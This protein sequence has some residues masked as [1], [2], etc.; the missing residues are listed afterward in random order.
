MWKLKAPY[1]KH[2]IECSKNL[3]YELKE[4]KNDKYSEKVTKEFE[5]EGHIF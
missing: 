4:L 2:H 1:V 3:N 5:D